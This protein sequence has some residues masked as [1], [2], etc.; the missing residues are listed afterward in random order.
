MDQ[1]EPNNPVYNVPLGIRLE[2]RLDV[3][4]LRRTFTE[5]VRRHEVLRTR[6]PAEAG[7]PMQKIMPPDSFP[8]PVVDLSGATCPETIAG[9]LAHEDAIRP[10]HL[11]RGPIL[12][13]TLIRNGA[14]NH[15]LL[16]AMHHI[17]TD[18]W[19]MG[20]LVREFN[21]LYQSFAA[22]RECVLPSLPIQYSDFARWQQERLDTRS[23]HVQLA[24]WREQLEDIPVL[25]L[26]LDLP[27]PGTASYRGATLP[28]LLR[29]EVT[30]A[31]TDLTQHEHATMFMAIVAL[32]QFVLGRWANQTDVAVGVPV[33]NRERPETEGLIGLFV[34]TVVLR[35]HVEAPLTFRKFLG[36][37]RET[38]VKA[39]SN[40][41]VPFEQVVEAL[42][43]RRDLSRTPLFQAMLIF[44]ETTAAE[45]SLPG[46]RLTPF[47]GGNESAKFEVCLT[48]SGYGSEFGCL[49]TY[50]TD[51]F[52]RSSMERFCQHLVAAAEALSAEPDRPLSEVCL[53]TPSER[54]RI[55]VEWNRT[56][57]NLDVTGSLDERFQQQAARTPDAVAIVDGDRSLTFGTLDEWSERIAQELI[58]SGVRPESRVGL[59]LERGDKAV[60][61]ALGCLRAGAAYVSLDPRY[62]MDRVVF[63]LSDACAETVLTSTDLRERIES[64]AYAIVV[65]FERWN[66]PTSRKRTVQRWRASAAYV[67][68]TSGSTGVPKGV[69]G[70]DGATLNRCE[71]AWRTYPFSPGEVCCLKAPLS[72]V[73]SVWELMGPLL[74]GIPCIVVSDAIVKEPRA[75]VELLRTHCVTRMVLVPSLLASLLESGI[76]IARELPNLRYW[77]CSGEALPAPLCRE[78]QER[79]PRGTLLNVYGSSEVAA[80]CTAAE[81]DAAGLD[82]TP[83]IGRPISNMQVYVLDESGQP[84]SEGITGELYVGGLGLSRGYLGRPR[85]TAERFVPDP[86]SQHSGSRLYR[87]GDLGCWRK[88]QIYFVGRNDHQVKVR[89]YRIE[90]AEIEA[91]LQSHAAIAGAV[92]FVHGDA[93]ERAIAACIVAGADGRVATSEVRERLAGILPDHM[94]PST[95]QWLNSFPLLPNGK[96]DRK[97]IAAGFAT[98]STDEPHEEPWGPVEEIIAGI[99]A[100]LLR[101]SHVSRD[102]NFFQVGGHS[103]LATRVILRLRDTLRVDVPLRVLFE[104]PTV[105]GLAQKIEQLKQLQRHVALAPLTALSHA[106][107]VP[108]SFGQERL[109]FISQLEPGNSAYNIPM[110]VL[111]RGSLSVAALGASINEIVRRHEVL[112][113]R[114]RIENGNSVQEVAT[115]S[116]FVI[117]LIDLSECPEL[118]ALVRRFTRDEGRAPFYLSQ[119]PLFRMRLLRLSPDRHVLSLTMHHIVT[120][121]WSFGVLVHELQQ[122]YTAYVIGTRAELFELPAQ[123]ADFAR[124]Q[125]SWMSGDVLREHLEY[126]RRQLDGVQELDLPTDHPRSA[127][128]SHRG[129]SALVSITDEVRAQL[130]QIGQDHGATLFMVLMAAF[131]IVLSRWAG[132][133][134]VVVGTPVANRN[135]LETEGLIGFFANHLAIRTRV[136][137]NPSFAQLLERVRDTVLDGYT[138]Q[139]LPFEKLVEELAPERQLG[140]NPLY[141]V[142]FTLENATAQEV[143]VPGLTLTPLESGHRPIRFDLFLSLYEAAGGLQGALG[144]AEDLFDL[145]T[146]ERMARH[147]ETLLQEV[148]VRLDARISELPMLNAAER[149]QLLQDACRN[150]CGPAAAKS[151]HEQFSVQARKAPDAVALVCGEHR[152]SYEELHRRSN[153]LARYLRHFGIGPEVRVMLCVNRTPE[154]MIGLMGVLKA[155]GAYVPLDPNFPIELKSCIL[156][157]VQPPVVLT[158]AALSHSLPSHWGQALCLDTDWAEVESQS[159]EELLGEIVESNP[160]YV[161]YTSGSTGRPK[162]VVINH[163]ALAN[164]IAA[165]SAQMGP[166]AGG[167]FALLSSF[168]ADLGNTVLY[169]SVCTGGELHV[170]SDGHERDPSGLAVYFEE[171]GIECTKITPSHLTMLLHTSH[172]RGALPSKL[173]VFG[174]EPLQWQWVSKV[175]ALNPE[176]QILN[177]YGPTETT[178]GVTTYQIEREVAP[179]SGSV[180]IGRPLGCAEL[181]VMDSHQNLAPVGAKGELYIGGPG[182]ARGYLNQPGKTAEKF[183]PH[184]FAVEA[185]ARLYRT[186]DRVRWTAGQNI[187]FLGRIDRQVKIRGYRVELGEIEAAV[188]QYPGVRAN[189][190][191]IREDTHGDLFVTSYVVH[192]GAFP[193]DEAR[194]TVEMRRFLMKKLPPWMIPSRF[195][196]LDRLPLLPNGKLDRGQLP[197]PLPMSSVSGWQQPGTPIEEIVANIWCEVLCRKSIGVDENFFEIGGH[198]LLATQVISRVRSTFGVELGVGSIF[199]A[200]TV[201]SLGSR[202]EEAMREGERDKA[203]PLVR[204]ARRE[205][206][207]LSFA[208][209]RLWFLNQL[210]PNNPFYNSPHGVM[211]NVKLDLKA[212]ESAINEIV[213]RH[214]ALRTRFEVEA[215]VPVQVI[216]E[217]APR[218]LEVQDLTILPSEVREEEV[219]RIAREEAETGFDLSRGPLL[220]VK[221]LKLEEEQHQLLYTMHHIVSDGWSMG[222]LAGE[223]GALY[224]AYSAGEPSPLEELP[225]QYAD[226]A[227]WQRTWLQGEVLERQIQYWREQLQGLEPLSLPTDYPRP[228]TASYRG[229]TVPISI[230]SEVASRLLELSRQEGVTLFMTLLAAVNVLMNRYTGQE[231]IV[232]GTNIANRTR[233]ELERIIG[234]FVNTLVLR[235]DLSSDPTFRTLLGRVRGV[236]LKAYA[237]QDLPFEKLVEELHPQRDLSQMP[238]FQ[239]ALVLQ[240][241]PGEPQQSAD[242][243]LGAVLADNEIAKFDLTFFMGETPEGLAG[244]IEY[245]IDL[246]EAA[247]IH[248]MRDHFQ[249][250]LTGIG[251][252]PGKPISSYSLVPQTR[253]DEIINDFITGFED[254]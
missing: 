38:V 39:L 50:A 168:A 106:T 9:R 83:P 163:R 23:L 150:R 57:S 252:D 124:W 10:F 3:N 224:Q 27:R 212:L 145:A 25:N 90:L 132:Q 134:D 58:R 77:T 155:G 238:L 211:V 235:T 227:V 239:V 5:I 146:A 144:Y 215:G 125:R 162:G 53:L 79:V 49:L 119:G 216:D 34:N 243:G 143:C 43:P 104:A 199:E 142:V 131:Q 129:G 208:Q 242:P 13:V 120:D 164:Y 218:R 41:D 192:V 60:A 172:Y 111:L 196:V 24:Y 32:F 75:F 182:V 42:R 122:L 233:Y 210:V 206:L 223:V 114:F 202:I 217:W 113:T 241:M 40:A 94:I 98:E 190:A 70:L 189:T 187:E 213:R 138:F 177:H 170:I 169:P 21:E 95:I 67:I 31:L 250:L 130:K 20:V 16:V 102:D 180:P 45:A 181:Y 126:W 68:Y 173:L 203:P 171:Q 65:D 149:T 96:I 249:A 108:L 51:L 179:T 153:Q 12:R 167:R 185:G 165:I 204:V 133:N 128:P 74:A 248:R 35:S 62:P 14:D 55:V 254:M 148:V 82:I 36:R 156:D 48:C 29:R 139:S 44:N 158:M 91:A 188:A 240:N 214:E 118:D 22:G 115:F 123:Y 46:L 72:F 85:L 184:P 69:V 100:R 121:A 93:A 195:I 244:S 7:E 19:S 97:A 246:F 89:G 205:R 87:T 135:L 63:M 160:A 219:R 198:S 137:G 152:L 59:Y 80:D 157:E 2:G 73:D 207:P 222:I 116:P 234:F 136:D 110:A 220:R 201:E 230:A 147:F 8:V 33:A 99:W 229:S 4:A 15:V 245:N 56:Q 103:L 151:A 26:P 231:D 161:I 186:E 101:R 109:W 225:I 112:R 61:A 81:I 71:W 228:A 251:A 1:L 253:E 193:D 117:P 6:F 154:L 107:P 226:F 166:A 88:G 52:D 178:V 237:H 159:S 66:T 84:V 28:F 18:G 232:I 191:V 197:E 37:V 221:V 176:G 54:E 105:R 76:D 64:S 247:T 141:Q 140:R 11:G 209:Q 78:F 236:T 17:V 200:A 30:L 174:G 86:F 183:V 47:G 92:A 127:A 194:M 175:G